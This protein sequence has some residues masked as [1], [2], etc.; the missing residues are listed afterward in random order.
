ML[1]VNDTL[2]ALLEMIG[3]LPLTV[4]RFEAK[5]HCSIETLLTEAKFNKVESLL[6]LNE[7][8]TIE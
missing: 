3:C 4:A 6:D 1:S 8:L 5:V 2:F 7:Q